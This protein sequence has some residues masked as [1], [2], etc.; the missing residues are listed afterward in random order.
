[1]TSYR[2]FI[3]PLVPIEGAAAA[4]VFTS[5]T[6]ANAHAMNDAPATVL[7]VEDDPADAR[8][9]QEALAG[10]EGNPFLSNG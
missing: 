8:L 5:L 6:P 2:R 1:M 4:S 10:T 3:P 7:L 9:I